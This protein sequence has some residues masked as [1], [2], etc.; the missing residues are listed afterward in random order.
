MIGQTVEGR[1]G[2]RFRVLREIGR[3]A[4]GTVYAVEDEI[5]GVH[6]L[7]VITPLA[8]PTIA[9]SFEQEVQSTAS[10][11]HE[12]VLRIV[13]QG[14]FTLNGQQGLFVVSEYCPD[15]DYRRRLLTYRAQPPEVSRV[16]SDFRQI[17]TGL[18]AL[19]TQIIHR[20]LK[21]ENVLV[22]GSLLKI[23][24]FGLARFVDA[25][26][27][28]LTFKGGGTPYYMAPEVWLMQRST[29][30]TD[31]Y[32]VGV[33]LYEAFIGELP[34]VAADLNALRDLHLYTP[35]PRAKAR[36][37]D[38][39]DIVDGIIKK[40][41]AKEPRARYQSA[42]EVL[43][44]LSSIATDPTAS[45][46][47]DVAARMR[48]QHDQAEAK[49]LQEQR[50][51]DAERDTQARN[52]YMEKELL[53]MADDVVAEINAHLAE[54]KIETTSRANSRVYGFGSRTLL[55]R[56]FH[57]REI[58][59][60]AQVPGRMAILRES[61]VVHGGVIEIQEHRQD[62]EGWNVVLIRPP[63]SMYGEWRLVESRVS[64]LS[65]RSTRYEPVATEAAL[66]ADNLACHWAS[67]MH[68]FNLTDK[69]LER[70]DLIRIFG[71]FVP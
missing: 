67:V 43:D 22:S 44:A 68:V 49:R 41:L 24:D 29:P 51:Q 55:F 19:H 10:V 13:D 12:N 8:D 69:S 36:N 53:A 34:F 17:L 9:V 33:M 54:T 27:R 46:L 20:D 61:H 4:F 38:V 5:R 70:E 26:T 58:Y 25:A 1:S 30:A 66:F 11:A 7:K 39:P 48:S 63:D 50:A 56:F 15:G 59:S 37:V 31:L 57:E 42:N 16:A 23:A 18:R 3:G 14:T 52:R 35:A 45:P 6:A 32:A 65:R 71:I 64:A 60:N 40:L 28:T 47:A 62:R 2:Q 21:P